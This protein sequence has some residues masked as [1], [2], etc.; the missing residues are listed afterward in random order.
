MGGVE[1]GGGRVERLG[2]GVGWGVRGRIRFYFSP[3]G[4]LGDVFTLSCVCV[5]G[6]GG[7][8]ACACVRV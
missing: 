6:G 5:W 1:V 7:V 2:G 8:G 4:T 3:V